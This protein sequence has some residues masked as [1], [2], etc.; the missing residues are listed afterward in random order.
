MPP[1]GL[2]AEITNLSKE[3]KGESY[4]IVIASPLNSRTERPVRDLRAAAR[5]SSWYAIARVQRDTHS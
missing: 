5:R 2:T 4:S 1:Y 3:G